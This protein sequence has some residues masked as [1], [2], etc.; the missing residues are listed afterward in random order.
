MDWATLARAAAVHT[1]AR[2]TALVAAGLA[3]TG[4]RAR[5]AAS[6]GSAPDTPSTLH[7][8]FAG[9]PTQARWR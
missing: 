5:F 7:C 4:T 1:A 2:Y 3:H 6:V 8:H 9:L